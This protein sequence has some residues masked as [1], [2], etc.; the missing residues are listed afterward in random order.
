VFS[1]HL[2]MKPI[3]VKA[4]HRHLD[5]SHTTYLEAAD[6]ILENARIEVRKAY[7]TLENLPLDHVGPLDISVSYD[8]SWQKRGF[9]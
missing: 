2:N 7:L 3:G 8:G 5:Q 4:Y 1:M 6:A 9:T